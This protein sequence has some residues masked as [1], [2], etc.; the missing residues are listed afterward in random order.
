MNPLLNMSEVADILRR[1]R[2]SIYEL[3]KKGHL[4]A[5]RDGPKLLK[6]RWRDV[7]EYIERNLQQAKGLEFSPI[8]EYMSRERTSFRK[9]KK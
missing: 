8:T 9:K 5:V 7:E 3:V 4:S 2:S 1:P 6:F